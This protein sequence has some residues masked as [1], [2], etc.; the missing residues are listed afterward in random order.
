MSRTPLAP[1]FTYYGGKWRSARRYPAPLHRTIIEPFAGSAGYSL[2]YPHHQ[3]MLSDV[4]PIIV[5]VWDYLIH[6]TPA[7]VLA[8]P[9]VAPDGTVDD[10]PVSQ[11]ARW[12]IGF[13]LNKGTASPRRRPSAWM[14]SDPEQT[15]FWSAAIRRRIA[16][17]LPAIAHW[18]IK[19][20]TY[21]DLPAQ[22]A[23]WF[24]DPPYQVAGSHYRHGSDGINYDQLGAWCQ[25]LPGQV[26]VCEA[27][28]ATWLPFTVHHSAK[29][30]LNDRRTTEVLWTYPPELVLE[31]T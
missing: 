31:L 22:P 10:L 4:D 15:Q 5:G 19:Q 3:V 18:S 7:E 16:D 20:A 6:A 12:L 26:I 24:V 23:T 21:A 17:Q 14:R 30:T 9:D 8:L 1:F 13:W 28:G 27:A 2:R 25:H 29:A 11:E